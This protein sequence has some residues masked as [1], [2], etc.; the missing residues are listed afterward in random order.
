MDIKLLE[1]PPRD[2]IALFQTALIHAK[3][4]KRSGKTTLT[5]SEG[6]CIINQAGGVGQL[7]TFGDVSKAKVDAG[8]WKRVVIAVSCAESTDKGKKGEMRTWVGTEPGVVLK[9]ESITAN[10]RFAID[11]SS[12]FLFS[13]AQSSMMPGK[14][15]IRTVRVENYFATDK[16]VMASRARDKVCSL[17]CVCRFAPSN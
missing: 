3:E 4:N 2:G 15:A 13:S 14:V 11:P 7:G 5:R 17:L 8:V 12:L 6:E 16:D 9:E 1:E 10:E